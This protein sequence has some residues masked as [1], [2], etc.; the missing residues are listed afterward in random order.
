MLQYF[1]RRLMLIP[2]TIFFLS[3]LFF[4]LIRTIPGDFVDFLFSETGTQ[5]QE[6]GQGKGLSQAEQEA[7][8]RELYGLSKPV[9]IQYVRWIGHLVRGDFGYSYTNREPALTHLLERLPASIE[10]GLL[11]LIGSTLL[12]L[13]LGIISARFPESAL[14]NVIRL[15]S[16]VGLST[17]SFVIAALLLIV[18]V[19]Q[20]NWMPPPFVAFT[21]DPSQNL[22]N[23]LFPVLVISFSSS[24]PLLRLTRSQ[25]LEVLGQ[26]YIRTARAKGL[27]AGRVF[28]YHAFRNAMLPIITVLGLSLER[29]ISGSVILE[30][31]FGIEGMGAALVY[32]ST[33][34][35]LPV[36]QL[37]VLMI[38]FSVVFMNLLVDMLYGFIDPR[39]RYD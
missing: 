11:G 2:L 3:L 37:F 21:E 18:L 28:F 27:R 5:A 32:A 30:V 7:K 33:R 24:A 10:L 6:V 14:D 17:P 9:H 19:T 8:L 34:R 36:L 4:F 26:D 39:V 31:V 22:Q 23:M 20:Y 25:M 15:L 16:L 38:G 12:G 29:L 1:I 35:D 13:P